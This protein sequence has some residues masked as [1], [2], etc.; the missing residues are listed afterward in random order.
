MSGLGLLMLRL[1]ETTVAVG[2]VLEARC[3]EK[4]KGMDRGRGRASTLSK[5]W[6]K[7]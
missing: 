1:E 5:Q 3:W 2:H 6:S 7:L 4:R